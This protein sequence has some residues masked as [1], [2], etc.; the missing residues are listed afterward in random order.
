MRFE[1]ANPRHGQEWR[2]WRH[3]DLP[4]DL[5]LIPQVIDCTT[6]YVQHPRNVPDRIL[7]FVDIVRREQVI[8]GTDCDF[9]TFA[10]YRVVDAEIV[11]AKLRALAE[12]AAIA[13]EEL[14]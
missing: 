12:G 2:T 14:F 10:G 4:D 7:C 1:A 11:F 9:A 8:V 3:A 5:V 6:N 13:S